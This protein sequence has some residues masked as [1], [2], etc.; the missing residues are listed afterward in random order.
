MGDKTIK[1]YN[2]FSRNQ[3]KIQKKTS[4]LYAGNPDGGVLAAAGQEVVLG[5]GAELEP[6]HRGFVP[7]QHLQ[8][9][10]GGARLRTWG[11]YI[12]VKINREHRHM[13]LHT[14]GPGD[15]VHGAAVQARGHEV[16]AGGVEGGGHGC[17]GDTV[18]QQQGRAHP[19]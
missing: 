9:G 14:R 6:G 11:R 2:I 5:A 16:A 1:S 15:Q 12:V 8:G 3:Q 4:Q 17:R 18:R 7:A 13:C 19:M 10:P